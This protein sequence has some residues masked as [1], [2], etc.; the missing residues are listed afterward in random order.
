SNPRQALAAPEIAVL[1]QA[2]GAYVF[3]VSSGAAEQVRV[4]TGQRSGG[5]AEVL[6]GLSEGDLVIT[7]GV[8]SVRPG[9]EVR[10]Q[11]G[12]A[13]VARGARRAGR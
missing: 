9:Q 3:R 5:M 12:P 11:E 13:S 10:A 6:S 8:Q 7:E 4:E 1:E 2:D